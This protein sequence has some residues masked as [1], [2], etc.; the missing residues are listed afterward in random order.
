MGEENPPNDWKY[1][2]AADLGLPAATAMRSA[3]REPG[4]VGSATTR[5]CWFFIER[6]LRRRFSLAI[7]GR[8]TLPLK[9]PFLMIANH[10]S[11]LDALVLGAAAPA[12]VRHRLF[13]IAA[14][15]T[16][17]ETRTSAALSTHLLNA[18]PM[19]RDNCGLHALKA[20]RAR[21][22]SGRGA[23]ILFPEGTRSRTGELNPFRP[24]AGMLVAGTSVPVFPCYIDGAFAAWPP[25]AKRPNP[26]QVSVR[27]GKSMTF[28]DLGNRRAGWQQVAERMQAS[29]EDMKSEARCAASSLDRTE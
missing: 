27:I 15:D 25:D 12:A 23:L 1:D 16:F 29:V 11:H 10:S 17:F 14:G 4:L 9:P 22:T 21:L 8:E 24:G 7:E 5:C 2:A 19:W 13:P 28:E 18:L 20:M 26:G 6:W 3:I